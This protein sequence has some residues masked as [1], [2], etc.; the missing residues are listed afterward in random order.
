MKFSQVFVEKKIEK[1]PLTHKV[2]KK[3]QNPNYTVID[4]YEDV[5]QKKKKPYLHKRTSLQLFLA[6]KKGE[7]IKK[8]PPAYGMS[9]QENHYYF[10]H[11]YNCIF[12]CEYCYLQ[13]HFNSPDIVLFLN[14]QEIITAISKKL[15][16]TP[17][18]TWFH[19]GEFSDSLALNH[20]TQEWSL[21]FDC[22]S[23][24]PHGILELR[25]KS[26]NIAHLLKLKPLKNA[27]VTFSLS[28]EKQVQSYDHQTSP[29]KARIIAME[30]LQNHGHP[31]GVH[32]DPLIITENFEQEISALF[33]MMEKHLSLTSISYYSLGVVRFT[34]EVFRSF[35]KNYPDS[36][37]LSSP[38]QKS[39]DGK[40]RYPYLL[41]KFL[42]EK[43]EEK[44]CKNYDVDKSKIYWCME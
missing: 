44:L 38:L 2:L 12:E 10:I 15:A 25:T 18:K 19:A 23:K 8:A 32:F 35:Q 21:Y 27:M 31:L 13:G 1:N 3:L 29:L 22:F 41:R 36:S 7:L 4:S 40:I 39:F 16:N 42:L 33:K 26:A 43:I 9:D 37:I 20:L 28:P 11:S 17:E 24:Y 6:E 34:P 14:H 30:K 5:F